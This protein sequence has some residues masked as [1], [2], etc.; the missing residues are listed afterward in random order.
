MD[1]ESQILKLEKEIKELKIKNHDLT[2]HIHLLLSRYK[3][4]RISRKLVDSKGKEFTA[5]IHFR[6]YWRYMIH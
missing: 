1:K 2:R 4:E 3:Q 6:P 5:T